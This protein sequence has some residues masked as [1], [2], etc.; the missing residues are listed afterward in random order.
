MPA[1]LRNSRLLIHAPLFIAI[2]LLLSRL[3]VMVEPLVSYY[4]ALAAMY[5]TA[6]FGMVIL[7]GLSGQVSLGNGALMAVGAYAV[8]IA[9]VDHRL[10][11]W[12]ALPLA[13]AAGA[14]MVRLFAIQHDCGHGPSVGDRCRHRRSD[15]RR[16]R[17]A[18]RWHG[19]HRHADDRHA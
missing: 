14:F 10:S 17:G 19:R 13:F 6:M 11:F 1:W 15:A 16:R 12:L 5:A 2:W 4:L 7:V 9:T 18:Q 8:A 3:N